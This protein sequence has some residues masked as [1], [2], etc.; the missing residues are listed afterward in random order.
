MPA[1][2]KWLA[3]SRDSKRSVSMLEA[4]HYY[5]M[6]FKKCANCGSGDLFKAY[7]PSWVGWATWCWTCGAKTQATE[8]IR[9][10]VL[11]ETTA[12]KTDLTPRLVK[13]I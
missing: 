5:R 13:K 6:S 8:G 4:K 1:M 7:D 9:F 10:G 2:K 3:D 12:K 11:H